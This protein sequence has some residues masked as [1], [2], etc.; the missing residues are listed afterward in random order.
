MG[1]MIIH[2]F[3]IYKLH[4]KGVW[5]KV[6]QASVQKSSLKSSESVDDNKIAIYNMKKFS[7][8]LMWLD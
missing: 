3:I 7:T 8:F 1:G 2:Y 6:P 5:L 4:H